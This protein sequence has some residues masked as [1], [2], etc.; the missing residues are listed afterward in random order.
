MSLKK[1]TF[2]DLQSSGNN[3]E[4]DFSTVYQMISAEGLKAQQQLNKI[5]IG[6]YWKIGRYVSEK[7]QSDGWG[8]SVVEELSRYILG[9]SSFN[10]GFSARN[11]W[12]MRQFYEAYKDK[13]N[14]SALLTEITWTNHLHILSKTKTLEE[15]T[16]YLT[17]ASNHYYS[18]R[19]FSH[20]IDSSTYER[21]TLANQKLSAALTVFPVS[22][23]G[24][25]KDSYVFDFMG[26]SDTHKEADLRR[27]IVKHLKQFLVEMGPDFSLIGEE[28]LLQVGVK[29]FRIDLLMYHRGLNCMVAIELKTTDFEPSHLG[30]LQFYLEV[31]DRDIKKSHENPSIGILICKTKDEEV[32][33]YAMNRHLSPTMVAEYETKLI[34]KALLHKKLGELALMYENITEDSL[35]TVNQN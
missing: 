12:R 17:L 27:G 34:N 26:L 28:Y 18:E 8:K 13:T 11:I 22:L 35:S 23:A 33:K 5:L 30:Q 24:I 16:F 14:L 9:K 2:S 7:I 15:K 1:P 25:F 3:F 20:L 19:E 6:L 10:K 29:D 32:V 21:T 4:D 31:L